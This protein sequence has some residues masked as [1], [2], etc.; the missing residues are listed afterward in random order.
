MNMRDKVVLVTGGGSGIGKAIALRF[1]Q[2]KVKL[3]IS[4]LMESGLEETK[5]QAE[6]MGAE[7][8]TVQCD[9]EK[10]EDIDH[11]FELIIKEYGKIDVLVNNVGIAGPSKPIMDISL[12][13][14]DQNMSV[15]LR[16]QFYSIK[17]AA[18]YM[19][20]NGGG[21]I[22]NISSMSGKKSLPYRSPYC[23]SKMGVIGLT[24]CISEEL[25]KY[26]ITV[27]AVC[28]GPVSGARL[29]RVLDSMAKEE[30]LT[31]DSVRERFFA[32]SH[33]K[34][35][36]DA[37][38]IAELVLFLSDEKKSKSITG[39]DINVNCGAITY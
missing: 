28:P 11:L 27:N 17:K 6:S 4:D 3:V 34:R 21:K 16:S 12:E 23:A 29:D 37:E 1:A 35:A 19:I 18:P 2:E 36:S 26:N 10:A 15:N 38:D 33:I 30:G 25:G 8:L 31:A 7:T 14:W 39:Q 32:P 5:K 9:A 22:V 24:R 20:E 13:E